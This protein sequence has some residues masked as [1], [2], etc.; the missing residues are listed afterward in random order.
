MSLNNLLGFRTLDFMNTGPEGKILK[1][2]IREKYWKGCDA[3]I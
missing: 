2:E 3:K 1:R